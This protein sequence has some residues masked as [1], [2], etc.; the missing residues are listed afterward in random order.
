[1]A[2]VLEL[3]RST[4]RH[5][6]CHNAHVARPPFRQLRS[7]PSCARASNVVSAPV[8]LLLWNQT[9][10][11]CASHWSGTSDSSFSMS[12]PVLEARGLRSWN[13]SC[14][15]RAAGA[16]PISGSSGRDRAAETGRPLPAGDWPSLP[17]AAE[18][19]RA[20]PVP[21]TGAQLLESTPCM[22]RRRRQCSSLPDV[23]VAAAATTAPTTTT[24][25]CANA[26]SRRPPRR[27][28]L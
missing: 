11:T 21:G 5:V 2:E 28:R 8:T 23:W 22:W 7:P 25:S 26:G 1:M 14:R 4:G 13:P 6:G 17:C 12:L 27:R 19:L 9:A 16:P 10:S 24:R 15:S 3:L 18:H 20:V